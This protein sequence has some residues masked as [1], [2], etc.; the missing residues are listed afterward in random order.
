VDFPYLR[1][2]EGLSSRRRGEGPIC[3]EVAS[4]FARAGI[5]DDYAARDAQEN[6][7][8]NDA[9]FATGRKA[10]FAGS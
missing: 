10:Y 9:L 1:F 2:P 3:L 6:G 7:W 5:P 4:V 8:I